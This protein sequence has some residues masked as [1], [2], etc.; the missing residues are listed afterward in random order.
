[1]SGYCWLLFGI[2]SFS[3]FH[4][5]YFFVC[6]VLI[7]CRLAGCHF[8]FPAFSLSSFHWLTFGRTSF[9]SYLAS[10][11]PFF[12]GYRRAEYIFFI[13]SACW[14]ALLFSFYYSLALSGVDR[15][16]FGSS[17]RSTL[18]D[19]SLFLFSFF[20]FHFLLFVFRYFQFSTFYFYMFSFLCLY[21]H[22]APFGSASSFAFHYFM[23][24]L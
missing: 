7:R 18:F 19:V 23:I 6:L 16:P 15:L 14:E 12:V 2:I 13:F 4:F 17:S 11:C 21:F 24:P 1:M 22:P 3:I 9:F 10:V 5:G 20:T 8:S